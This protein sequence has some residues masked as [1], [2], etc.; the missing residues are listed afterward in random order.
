MP[1]SV[2]SVVA[3]W[4][5]FYAMAGSAAA[6][7]VGLLFTTMALR[8]DRAG[9]ATLAVERDLWAAAG[10]P[11][12]C[13][14]DILLIS[15]DVLVPDQSALGLGLPMLSLAA[16][17]A[18]LL[19]WVAM[20]RWTIPALRWRWGLLTVL[21]CYLVQAVVAVL[22]LGGHGETLWILA[23]AIG[24][25]IANAAAFAWTL[26]RE[27]ILAQARHSAAP[28]PATPPQSRNS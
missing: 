17:G 28:Q 14:L 18:A 16:L 7:L 5:D 24:G 4:H 15:L 22:V 2:S 20:R 26:L 1:G 27:P 12:T 10:V 19:L 13:F 3:Q 25:L 11:L 6:V 21:A 23:L 9:E 8:S